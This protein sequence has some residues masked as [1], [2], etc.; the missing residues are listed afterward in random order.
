MPPSEYVGRF[1]GT[2]AGKRVTE[3][4]TNSLSLGTA[5]KWST[6]SERVQGLLN[7]AHLVGTRMEEYCLSVSS[8]E[9]PAMRAIRAKMEATPWKEEWDNKRTMFAYGEE[10]STDPLEAQF[11]KAMVAMQRPKRVLE[12]GMFVGYGAAGMLEG[13]DHT[14]V[15]SLEID[16]YLKTWVGDCLAAFPDVA[17]RHTVV[18]GPALE[19]LEKLSPAEPFDLVFV[20]AN[21]SEYKGYVEALLRRNLLTPHAMIMA[22]NT[23]YCGYPYTP[24]AFDSQPKRRAFGEA[25]REFNLWVAAHPELEQVVLP[26]RDGVSMVAYRPQKAKL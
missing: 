8:M 18:K 22:D 16:P 9:G 6:L 20:D 5:V 14:H 15:V 25:I 26:L 23:L 17:K 10:M 3:A 2:N 13:C 12:V 24:A 19:S 21:K 4:G 7:E 1:L 11:L